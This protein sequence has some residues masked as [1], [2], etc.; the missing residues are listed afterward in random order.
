MMNR[1]DPQQLGGRIRKIRVEHG[2]SQADIAKMLQ[3]SRSSVVQMEK[4]KRQISVIELA[5]LSDFLGFSMDHF[6]TQS[7]ELPS[8]SLVTEEPEIE[9]EKVTIRDSTPRLNRAKLE[10]VF[11]YLIEYCGAKPRMEISLLLN[12]LYF[13][14][15]NHYELHEEQLTGLLYTK[16]AHG[17]TPQNISPILKEMEAKEKL[18]KVKCSHRGIPQYRYLPGVGANLKKLDAAEKEVIDRVIGQFSDW[19]SKALNHYVQADIPYRATPSGEPI[20]YELAFYRRPP[21][22]VRIYDE[23]WSEE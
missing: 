18:H 5:L 16:Q 15:F 9:M 14:D 12:M 1:I 2:Y 11:L 7:Y 8:E 10:A 3:V 19:P 6:L 22:S 17:P 13:C 23:D 4:G 21:Y 20:D